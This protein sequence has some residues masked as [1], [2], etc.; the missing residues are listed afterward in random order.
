MPGTRP[1]GAIAAAWAA[2]QKMG[3]DGY[4]DHTARAL[5]AMRKLQEGIARIDGIRVLS[6]PDATLL[7]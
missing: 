2:L 4:M 3:E 1:G 5:E 7:P 6:R